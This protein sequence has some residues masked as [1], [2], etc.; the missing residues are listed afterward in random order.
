MNE[1]DNNIGA[2][3]DDRYEL[4]EVIG[5]GGMAMVYRALDHRL[6]RYV[7]VKVLR[8]ELAE[9]PSFRAR[10][11]TESKAV[12]MLSHP[13]IVAV[14]D[15]SHS[16]DIDYI[17]MELIEGVT[18]KKYLREK[19]RLDCDETAGITAQVARALSH[20]HS[21]GLVHRDIKPQNLMVVRD[22]TVKV[23]DF[24][25][26]ALQSELAGADNETIGSVHYLSPEQA[27]G[28]SV[29][30]RS[31]IYS[32]GI[33][34]YEMLTGCLPFDDKDESKIPLLHITT[35]PAPVEELA[36]DI[37]AELVRITMKAMEPDPDKR[38]QSADELIADLDSF[39]K[40]RSA[41]AA[42]IPGVEP[43][44]SDG[45]LSREKYL[46]RR[47]RAKTVSTLSGIFG[48]LIFI[49]FV[50]VFLWNYWL[51]DLFS[52]AQRV[53]IPNFVGEDYETILNSGNYKP[54]S[55]TFIYDINPDVPEGVIISQKPEAGKSYMLT[56]SGIDVEITV[57]TGVMMYEI[58]NYVNQD[59]MD[60]SV[61]LEK[62]GFK[63]DKVYE[64]SESVTEGYVISISPA[65]GEKLPAGSTVYL[66]I[67][68]GP[69]ITLVIMPN[70]V[71]KTRQEAADMLEALNLTLMPINYVESD[72]YPEGV[73]A[74]Q[75]VE[76]GLEIEAHYKIY[77]NV[78]TGPAE[79]PEP[80]FPPFPE[81][82]V[83]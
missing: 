64:N 11:R 60:A 3:L 6:N 61:Q 29:D 58:P 5:S 75:N 51:N 20:A 39:L 80:I 54:F 28:L 32:L 66:K 24:G 7:A 18:L 73:V 81:V 74:G 62:L 2:M 52:E 77:L 69:E 38:Y 55:F 34:M 30:G 82:P 31:D 45:E 22:G 70:L 36:P 48:V 26:A 10:F 4:L 40:A 44:S 67:S 71:G 9:D 27:K 19:E 35:I 1:M 83:F 13:N 15:V 49:L 46:R 78:S 8:E 63:V 41:P 43:I 53:E 16:D 57:S 21:R 25:I 14:F 12:A 47:R 23:A 68:K 17:V 79:T 59:Y 42:L 56:D 76:A 37:P 50:G 33:V 72:E 65:P